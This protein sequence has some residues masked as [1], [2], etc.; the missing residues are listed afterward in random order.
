MNRGTGRSK[1]F[2]RRAAIL[3]GGKVLLL[4]G[5]GVR[6]HDLQVKNADR[7]ALLAEEN[8][9][10]LRLLVP[11][12]GHLLD[13]FGIGV[14]INQQN[15]RLLITPEHS[16]DVDATLS[17]LA[18][19]LELDAETKA[20]V[21]REA[22]RAQSFLPVTVRENLTWDEVALVEVNAPDLPGVTVE[23]GR[24]RFY[25]FHDLAA[26]ITGYVAAVSEA[27]LTDDPLVRHPDFR[28]GKSG[29]EKS[30]DTQLRG[31]PGTSQ[32]EVNAY[33]RVIRELARDEGRPGD[34]IELT[35]DM[36]LQEMAV[37]RFG[38]E[39]G[40][41]A[42]IDVKTGDVLALVTV[43]SYD[44]EPFT[45]GLTRQE[46]KAL[47]ED[48][49]GPLNDKSIAGQYPPGST[50]KMMVALTALD[51][52]ILGPGHGVFCP[53]QMVLGNRTFHCWK[54]GGHG[55]LTMV[56]ALQQ[57]CDVYFYDV[58]RR[59]GVDRIAA[60]SQRFGLGAVTGLDLP[61]EKPGL[62]PTS[63]WK[64]AVKG[65]KWQHGD[66][67]VIGIGQGYMLTTPIQLALMA[68][69]IGSNGHAVSPRLTR[70]K[71]EAPPDAMIG[72]KP[73]HL[74][75]VRE[76]MNL[77]TNSER[78]TAYRARIA[79]PGFEMA[80]K[81]G[82]V[83]V[84]RITN[85]ERD[86]KRKLEDI[87][88]AQ[89]DHGLFVAYAPVHDPRYAIAVVVEHGGSG[90]KAAAPIARDILYEAQRRHSAGLLARS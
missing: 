50:F 30:Y 40:S 26:N 41:T 11:R 20:R 52:G 49:R 28:I 24:S 61:G 3:G 85:A 84:R 69:R 42:V 19:L 56:N 16:G 73:E 67:V 76:G 75:L 82:T 88:W 14:A 12:R 87:P 68:A 21:L 35:I 65:E 89:R 15:Y 34:D 47:V 59:V 29:V 70:L 90:S 83:Q 13:R 62:T 78:G 37:R 10:N 71:P 43:P 33:G 27:E 54:K 32:V 2:A 25:P 86:A 6:L 63:A 77:V 23:A 64:E 72:L 4:T 53:G 38:T 55:S 5:L 22:H 44:P 80:G 8:R 66:T 60:M 1:T 48:P 51:S 79:E 58:A 7:Y 17:E 18:A 74:A 46:W 57:S 81:T 31:E 9:I 39:S 45:R 36:G